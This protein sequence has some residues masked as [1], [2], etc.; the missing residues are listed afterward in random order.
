MT[1]VIHLWYFWDTFW[2][3]LHFATCVSG[4]WGVG[5]GG[6]GSDAPL[7]C[8]LPPTVTAG[9]AGLQLSVSS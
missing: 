7:S 3:F 4:G 1:I 9:G 5:L 8:V 6:G 2:Y